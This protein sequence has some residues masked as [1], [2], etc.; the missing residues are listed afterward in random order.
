MDRLQNPLLENAKKLWEERKKEKKFDWTQTSIG[1]IIGIAIL[2]FLV[3]LLYNFL[4]ASEDHTFEENEALLVARSRDNIITPY[5]DGVPSSAAASS[6]PALSS[7][8]SP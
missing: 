6:H 2:A 5:L 3:C 7:L 8:R 1:G 4:V